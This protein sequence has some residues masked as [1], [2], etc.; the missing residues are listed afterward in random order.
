MTTEAEFRAKQEADWSGGRAVRPVMPAPERTEKP[1]RNLTVSITEPIGTAWGRAS[2]FAGLEVPAG[3]LFPEGPIPPDRH[4]N[5]NW[6]VPTKDEKG[7]SLDVLV[8]AAVGKDGALI[9]HTST[10]GRLK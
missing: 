7:K 5:F 2:E 10:V 3:Q 8:R 9:I 6:I 4:G 1:P